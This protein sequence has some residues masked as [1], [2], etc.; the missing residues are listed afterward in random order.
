MNKR[1]KVSL[2]LN[3]LIVAFVGVAF[4]MGLN[5]WQFVEDDMSIEGWELL[6]YFTVQ[7]NILAGVAAAVFAVYEIMLFEDKVL[8]IPDWVYIFKYAANVGVTVTFLTVAVYLAPVY[9]EG[10][11]FKF[12]YNSNLFFHFLVPVLSFVSFSFFELTDAITFKKAF[13]GMAHFTVYGAIYMAVAYTHVSTWESR[14]LED[15]RAYNWYG[16]ADVNVFLTVILV[17]IMC[18]MTYLICVATWFI[19]KKMYTKVG[20]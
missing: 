6:K 13:W 18:L 7:S 1:L 2:T 14:A 20:R 9:G 4:L 15:L 5:K 19:N 11:Y 3:I 12:F 17:L 8:K 10:N 16:F